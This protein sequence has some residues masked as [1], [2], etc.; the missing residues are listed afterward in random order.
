MRDFVMLKNE[1]ARY[2]VSSGSKISS[3][4]IQLGVTITD[5]DMADRTP[6]GKAI[7]EIGF[8][9]NNTLFAVWSQDTATLFTKSAGI[10]VPLAYSLDVSYLPADSMSVVVTSDTQ[11]MASLIL[12]HEAKTD[13]HPQYATDTDLAALSTVV[14]TKQPNLGFT[15][16]QQGGV[17]GQGSNKIAIGLASDGSGALK[18]SIDG[19]DK[20]GIALLQSPAFSGVPTVPTAVAG[21]ATDQAASTAFVA[22]AISASLVGQIVWEPRTT[23]RAGYLKLNGALLKRTDYPALWAYAQASGALVADSVWSASSWGCF[24]SGDG[25]TTFRLP[26]LRGESIRCWDDSRGIDASRA[27][28]T[29]QDGQN[30]SHTHAASATAVSDHTH[31]AYTD[32]QGYHTHGVNDPTHAHAFPPGGV[33]QAGGDNGGITAASAPNGYGSRSA[34]STSAAGTGVSIAAAGLHSHNVGVNAAGGHSHTLTVAA[35]GGT[36]VR[37]RSVAMLAMIRAY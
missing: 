22:A 17:T 34:Q 23:A 30:V 37:V 19:V 27:I 9:S 26:E 36:E 28:G 13:P 3:T 16:V 32:A 33:G 11:G 15:P 20:G 31:T 2:A 14:G 7:G 6:N 12:Q 5:T 24:S 10:D 1:V 4:T 29:W 35:A 18:V 25:V 8:Y 21:T